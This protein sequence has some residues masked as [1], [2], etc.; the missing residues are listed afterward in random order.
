MAPRGKDARIEINL[1]TV[2]FGTMS[3]FHLKL[4]VGLLCYRSTQEKNTRGQVEGG[5][6]GEMKGNYPVFRAT[7]TPYTSLLDRLNI[8]VALFR[9]CERLKS[10]RWAQAHWQVRSRGDTSSIQGQIVMM[11]SE[12]G[13]KSLLGGPT[14]KQ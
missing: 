1:G 8:I 2:D 11:T 4:S 7:H 10:S 6:S 12:D 9:R 5:V 3:V 13:G 14:C